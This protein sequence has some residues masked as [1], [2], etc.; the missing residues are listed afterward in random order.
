MQIAQPPPGGEHIAL[1]AADEFVVIVDRPLK[2]GADP[3]HVLGG[4]RQPFVKL[5]AEPADL[6]RLAREAVLPPDLRDGAGDGDEVG[7]GRQQHAAF[8]R[9]VPQLRFF[10]E[11]GGDEMLARHEH[12]HIVGR[13]LELALIALR[14]ERLDVVLHRGDM[15][16]QRQLAGVIVF[17][18]ERV[19]IG[20]ER[21]LG[22][23]HQQ[24]VAR[25][26]HDRIGPQPPFVGIDR[27]LGDEIGMLGQPALFE[28]VAQLL[29]APAPARLGGVAQ[30]IA[31]PRRLGPH[32]FLPGPHRLDLAVELAEGVGALGFEQGDLLLIAL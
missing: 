10:L 29:L 27:L 5:A 18:L 28:H 22:V 14:A 21:N 7:R 30:R 9:E 20:V 25:H 12:Q 17:R 24:L 19:L 31:E 1:E 4:D 11:R 26:P 6:A 2:P 3:L 15:R 8:E 16:H 13:I 32:L 23:D